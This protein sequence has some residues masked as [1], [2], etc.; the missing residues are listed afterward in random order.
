MPTLAAPQAQ[1][2][3]DFVGQVSQGLCHNMYPRMI[4]QGAGTQNL[5]LSA[6][7]LIPPAA[8]DARAACM[9]A[10]ERFNYTVDITHA[11]SVA[12]IRDHVARQ[13]AGRAETLVG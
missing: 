13:R 8:K 11:H 5:N 12:W 9:A 10:P 6:N 1:G 4:D 2:F 3:D 7:W